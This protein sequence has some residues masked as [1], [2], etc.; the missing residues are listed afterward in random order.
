[1][2]IC[3]KC[4]HKE[5]G[6][7]YASA[8]ALAEDLRRFQCGEP[9]QARPVGMV[10]RGWL[11]CRRRPVP[12]GLLTALV[13]ALLGSLYLWHEAAAGKRL[14]ETEHQQTDAARRQADEHVHMLLQLLTA[15]LEISG[16]S[17]LQK[18]G[19]YPISQEL[20]ATAEAACT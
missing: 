19:G 7:R 12:A 16:S 14:A 9:I 4:L 13:W 2:T 17:F 1:E 20:L 5:P 8:D 10:E 11:W 18:Q 3:L 15:N 6:R